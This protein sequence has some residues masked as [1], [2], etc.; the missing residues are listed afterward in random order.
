VGHTNGCAVQERKGCNSNNDEFNILKRRED[1]FKPLVKVLRLVDGDVKP[2]MGFLFGG[3]TK[4]KR[5]VKQCYGNMEDHYKNVMVIVDKKTKGRLDSPLHLTAYLLNPHYSYVDTSLFDD[6]TIIQGF[7]T[8]VETFYH[9]AE[10][11]QYQVVNKELRLFQNKEAAFVKKL[12]R[13]YQN[14]DN[15]LGI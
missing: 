6:A 12:A 8:C 15:I 4:A 10:D 1:V 5:E 13:S 3:L 14:F 9:V 2:S 7:I 11:M